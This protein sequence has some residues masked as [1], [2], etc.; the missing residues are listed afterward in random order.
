M[1]RFCVEQTPCIYEAVIILTP[2][3]G[4]KHLPL[5]YPLLTDLPDKLSILQ[6]KN[7]VPTDEPDPRIHPQLFPWGHRSVFC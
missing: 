3:V 7:H 5:L 2:L 6:M 4:M 1:I